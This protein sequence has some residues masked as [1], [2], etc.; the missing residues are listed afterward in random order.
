MMPQPITAICLGLEDMAFCTAMLAEPQDSD[1]PLP[2]MTV[3][4]HHHGVADLLDVQV[5]ALGTERPE[6]DLD[7]EHPVGM[8]ADRRQWG[9]P[10][11]DRN[12]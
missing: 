12:G 2:R 8:G 1:Q 4:V 11:F 7:V 10:V 3:I 9:Y 6:T 5:G